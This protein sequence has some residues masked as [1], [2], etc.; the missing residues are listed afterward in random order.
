MINVTIEC[1][2]CEKVMFEGRLLG[3]GAN[4]KHYAKGLTSERIIKLLRY[5]IG[6][7]GELLEPN[8]EFRFEKIESLC[9]EC[10][11]DR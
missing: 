6:F 10:K 8:L 7:L 11:E 1:D 2:G 3:K 5:F 4:L 9:S